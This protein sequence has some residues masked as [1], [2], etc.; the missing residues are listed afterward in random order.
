MEYVDLDG[1]STTLPER[2][3]RNLPQAQI[4]SSDGECNLH[5]YPRLQ[6]LEDNGKLAALLKD[7]P[8][9]DQ[10][11]SAPRALS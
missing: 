11:F 8:Q 6:E 10:E 7:I 4:F 3:L 9:V 2:E 1:A 5:T